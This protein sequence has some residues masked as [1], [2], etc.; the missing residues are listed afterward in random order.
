MYFWMWLIVATGIGLVAWL[1]IGLASSHP[2]GG[3][4]CLGGS[5]DNTITRPSSRSDD[6]D[7]QRLTLPGDR[8]FALTMNT[9]RRNG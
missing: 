3:C 9:H 1:A 8:R 6:Q 7:S 4:G 5:G 2:G